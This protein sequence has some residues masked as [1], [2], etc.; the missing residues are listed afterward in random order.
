MLQQALKLAQHSANEQGE[1]YKFNYDRK[2]A[3]HKFEISQKVWLS[4]TTSIGKN[5]KLVPNWIGPFEMK[6]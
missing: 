5:A 2:S 3:L 4:Y 6:Y 1:K